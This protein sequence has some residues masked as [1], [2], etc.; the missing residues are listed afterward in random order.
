MSDNDPVWRFD[1]DGLLAGPYTRSEL[2]DFVNTG[3]IQPHT[4]IVHDDGRQL[5]AQKLGLFEDIST[6]LETHNSEDS[7]TPPINQQ[8]DDSQP[9]TVENPEPA[10]DDQLRLREIAETDQSMKHLVVDV[11]ALI[12]GLGA[13]KNVLASDDLG[14]VGTIIEG[15]LG[16]TLLACFGWFSFLTVRLA[17]L[18]KESP[19]PYFVQSLIPLFNLLTAERL[20]R[21]AKAVL[22]R[23]GFRANLDIATAINPGVPGDDWLNLAQVL[24]IVGSVLAWLRDYSPYLAHATFLMGLIHLAGGVY[25]FG[26]GVAS[27]FARRPLYQYVPLC[28]EGALVI[29]LGSLCVSSAYV[30]G[31]KEAYNKFISTAAPH[32]EEHDAIVEEFADELSK[33]S[34][35]LRSKADRL[36]NESDDDGADADDS[37]T[38]VEDQYEAKKMFVRLTALEKRMK[39]VGRSLEQ[40]PAQMDDIKEM[41]SVLVQMAQERAQ[42]FKM[43]RSLFQEPD[44]S[45]LA[46]KV[47]Q[48]YQQADRHFERFVTL[49]NRFFSDHELVLTADDNETAP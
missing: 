6:N 7:A 13:F 48:H 36:L 49:R 35:R 20:R 21:Q 27:G 17:R 10:F 9:M 5:T 8:T 23:R 1:D 3:Y 18:L 43:A 15:L 4:E 38:E 25:L 2:D 41:R 11:L 39:A 37:E 32:L 33:H 44:R 14:L 31:P 42:G 45:C 47:Q 46:E 28:L 24:L 40:V 12:A 16:V 19:W 29:V 26:R 34:Q 22:D 30:V